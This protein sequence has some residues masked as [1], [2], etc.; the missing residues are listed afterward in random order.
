MS[1]D[2]TPVKLL[3][4][5]EKARL[6]SQIAKAEADIKAKNRILAMDA[7]ER[8]MQREIHRAG[9]KKKLRQHID[10]IAS[11]LLASGDLD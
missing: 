5:R 4:K 1:A 3:S 7:I 8:A 10:K 6:M 2:R 9:G 11:E